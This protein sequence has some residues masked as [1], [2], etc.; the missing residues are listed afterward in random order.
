MLSSETDVEAVVYD[1]CCCC[2]EEVLGLIYSRTP[3]RR[4][5][6]VHFAVNVAKCNGPIS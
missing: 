2:D 1:C 3:L 4:K 6:I 5:I